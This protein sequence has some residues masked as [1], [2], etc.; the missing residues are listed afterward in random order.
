MGITLPP[1]SSRSDH[2]LAAGLIRQVHY[3]SEDRIARVPFVDRSYPDDSA[4]AV[5]C[6]ESARPTDAEQSALRGVGNL[7]VAGDFVYPTPAIAGRLPAEH[8]RI[9][10]RR[11]MHLGSV[12][13]VC[14]VQVWRKLGVSDFGCNNVPRNCNCYKANFSWSR[15]TTRQRFPAFP[16]STV[17]SRQFA[18]GRPHRLAASVVH[19]ARQT[20]RRTSATE[21][22]VTKRS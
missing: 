15:T 8:G 19:L 13:S 16:L 6:R 20:M 18:D 7:P 11:D 17:P 4:A 5:A 10:S 12:A 1:F 9:G 3:G 21:K 2:I 22:T 14:R